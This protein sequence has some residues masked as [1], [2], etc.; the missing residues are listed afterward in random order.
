MEMGRS[1]ANAPSPVYELIAL[2]C[3]GSGRT[4]GF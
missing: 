4:G 1:Q 3:Q 2:S